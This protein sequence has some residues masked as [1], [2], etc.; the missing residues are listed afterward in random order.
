REMVV[1]QA[2]KPFFL[3]IGRIWRER[4]IKREGMPLLRSW[5]DQAFH[6]SDKAV[7]SPGG[8][9]IEHLAT[10]LHG[11]W[12]LIQPGQCLL[13]VDRAAEVEHMARIRHAQVHAVAPC[14]FP[15]IPLGGKLAL[16]AQ[17]V[18]SN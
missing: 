6:T 3:Q 5:R 4:I 10:A 8:G 13:R 11:L 16:H 15:A 18:V 14:S 12:L 17:D 1:T 7:R 9:C 2:I